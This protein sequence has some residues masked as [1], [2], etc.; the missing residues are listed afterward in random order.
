MTK[1]GSD[2][3]K[4]DSPEAA[5]FLSNLLSWDEVCGIAKAEGFNSD[6]RN[7]GEIA[8]YLA[9]RL[10]QARPRITMSRNKDYMEVK[11]SKTRR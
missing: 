8:R 10:H 5:N 9:F 2:L 4:W 3:P 6:S 11:R 7:S 1:I